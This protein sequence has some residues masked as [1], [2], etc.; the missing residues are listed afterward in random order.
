[1]GYWDLVPFTMQMAMILVTGY[2]AATSPPIHR[3]IQA[4]ASWPRTQKSAIHPFWMLPLLGILGIKA[5]D[6]LGYCALQFAV[7]VPVV[8]LLV[9]ALNYTLQ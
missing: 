7:H 5:R 3:A 2:V 9:W 1:V 6:I 8:L 4:M